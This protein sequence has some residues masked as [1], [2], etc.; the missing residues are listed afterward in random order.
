MEETPRRVVRLADMIR[1]S[2]ILVLL[3]VACVSGPPRVDDSGRIEGGDGGVVAPREM[4]LAQLVVTVEEL[5]EVEIEVVPGLEA[6]LE[7]TPVLPFGPERIPVD[8]LEQFVQIQLF[9]NDLIWVRTDRSVVVRPVVAGD[10]GVKGCKKNY[11]LPEDL[12]R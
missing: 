10:R 11:Q 9:V 2:R 8:G 5:L 6:R 4:S 7:E 12:L 1:T 3:L